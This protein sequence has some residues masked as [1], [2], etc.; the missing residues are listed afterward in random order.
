MKKISKFISETEKSE[1]LSFVNTLHA[2]LDITNKHVGQVA[3]NLNGL[4]YMF[5]ITKSERSSTLSKF[6][7]SDNLMQCHLPEIFLTLLDRISNRLKIK[8]SDVFL[9]IIDQKSGGLI[10]PHYDSAIDGF[11]T[12]KANISVLSEDYQL[13]LGDDVLDIS[14]S[15][16]YSFEA[17]LYKH[18]TL[19]FTKRRVILSFGFI[20]PYKDLGRNED[21]KRVR[22]S[23]RIIKYFQNIRS[24]QLK[25]RKAIKNYKY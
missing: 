14:E 6:Q 21:D 9:Q 22:L 13:M 4:S 7:S 3:S 2:D 19:P 15:D 12:Y 23:K 20:L 1:I 11:I 10:Y 5:D 16:L 24:S 8:K 17:S 18:W 25:S